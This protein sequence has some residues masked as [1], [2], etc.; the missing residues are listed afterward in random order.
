MQ[1]VIFAARDAVGPRQIRE[2]RIC[3]DIA[4]SKTIRKIL[5]AATCKR[6]DC[7]CDGGDLRLKRCPA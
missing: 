7:W 4:A 6:D 5:N 1:I 2:L 3:V